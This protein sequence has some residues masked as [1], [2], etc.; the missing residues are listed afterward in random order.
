M[1]DVDIKGDLFDEYFNVTDHWSILFSISKVSV[2]RYHQVMAFTFAAV[3]TIN[4]IDKIGDAKVD[5]FTYYELQTGEIKYSFRNYHW[6][7]IAGSIQPLKLLVVVIPGQDDVG[8]G[9][10]NALASVR[11]GFTETLAINF[12]ST[13]SIPLKRLWNFPLPTLRR[14]CLQVWWKRYR[15]RRIGD[16]DDECP[17]TPG[18]PEFNGCPDTDGD[19]IEDRTMLVQMLL[20]LLNSMVVPIRMVMV[21][22]IHKMLVL[23]YL[24]WLPRTVVLMLTAM[25]LPMQ[26][27]SVQM[28]QAQLPIMVALGQIVMVMVF[29][30][31]RPVSRCTWNRGQQRLSRSYYRNHQPIERVL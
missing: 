2:G 13:L 17:E 19:G 30:T 15:W 8:F 22:L 11:F 12:Q 20:V 7:Q 9:T 18:L 31:R 28:K 25:V 10:A 21:F 24:D 27:I 26:K 3:G 29:L 23:P 6:S 5:D 14:H 4:K 16:K 1:G